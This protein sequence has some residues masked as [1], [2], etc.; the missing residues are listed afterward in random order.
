MEINNFL[1]T[2]NDTHTDGGSTV[3]IDNLYPAIIQCF[4]IILFGYMA[5]RMNLI[6][7]SHGKG[8]GAFVSKFCLP[9]LLF[10]NM[11]TLDFSEVNW[12][13]LFGVLISKS[14]IFIMVVIVT[15][16]AR[17]PL[18][19]GYAGLFAI[20]CTQSN[21]FALGYPILQAL[22][23]KT[24]PSNTKLPKLVLCIFSVI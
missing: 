8:I 15:L 1:S 18:H 21:D 5:G 12:M 11:C 2:S 19:F 23:E 10:K 20:F 13:F 24:H 17:R 9:A 7:S 6:S 14:V 3:S 22:Y 16:V 4:V